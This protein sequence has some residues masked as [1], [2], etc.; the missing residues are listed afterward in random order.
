M[1]RRIHTATALALTFAVVSQAFA[2]TPI[3]LVRP[4][5][6]TPTG[7]LPQLKVCYTQISTSVSTSRLFARPCTSIEA[8]GTVIIR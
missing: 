2:L 3:S 7:G 8:P 1:S 4:S 6:P 5:L